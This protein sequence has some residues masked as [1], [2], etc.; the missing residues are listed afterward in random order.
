MRFPCQVAARL[1][2]HLGDRLDE[3]GLLPGDVEDLPGK[4]FDAPAQAELRARS[5]LERDLRPLE[6]LELGELRE[7]RVGRV[8]EG[9]GVGHGR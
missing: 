3:V 2:G 4:R 9:L 7:Q 8:T 5:R 6:F 1:V